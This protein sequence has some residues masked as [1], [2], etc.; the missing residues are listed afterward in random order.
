MFSEAPA[1]VTQVIAGG[2]GGSDRE[3]PRYE[4]VDTKPPEIVSYSYQP[5]VPLS[6]R[7]GTV[8]AKIIDDVEVSK[9][10]LLYFVNE[11]ELE[12]HQVEMQKHNS[13]YYMGTIPASDI[14][15]VGL[16]YWIFAEDYG[17]NNVQ[18]PLQK[19]YVEQAPYAPE[20]K[21]T[22]TN[23]PAHVLE[24][25]NSKPKPTQPVEKLEVI[26]MNNGNEI[27]AYPDK[28]IIKN[29]GNRTVGNVRVILSTDISKSFK[30]SEPAI[31]SIEPNSNV[32]ITLKL[33]G[34]P[35]R[36]MLGGLVGYK[37][38]LMVITEHLSPIF[39][40]VNIGAV[41]SYHLSSYI[42][43]LTSIAEQ[44]QNKIPLI[45]SILSKQPK[46]QQNYEVTT[47]D[48]DKVIASASDELVIKNLSDK[49]LKNVR[50]YL[51]NAGNVFLLEQK[52]IQYLEPNGQISIKLIPRIDAAKYS[53]KDIKGELYI[54]PSNDKPTKI[55]ID[56]IGVER[57]D[58]ADEFEVR[59]LSGNNGIFTAS[60]K[61]VIKNLGNRTLDSVRL[62]LPINL[63][64][65][66]TLS[67][68]SFKKIEPNEEVTVDIKFRE[69]LGEHKMG[70]QY[71][72]KGELAIVS[73]HHRQK[74]IP[75]N[76]VWN[77]FSSDHFVI[78]A[79]SNET[80]IAKAK[81]LLT[82]L[83]SNYQNV[84]SRFGEM[85]AKTKIYMTNTL[86]E[87][88]TIA[89]S[90]YSYY[91]F[92]DDV[93]F[94]CGCDEDVKSLAMKEF[95]HRIT[96]NKYP[97]YA[98]KAK[99]MLDGE[100]WLI[101]G[102]ANYIAANMTNEGIVKSQLESFKEKPM[103]FVW[104]GSGSP[105]EYGAT[106][107]FF[108]YL[109]EKYGENVI[110]K[111]LYYL[112]SGMISNHRCD[113]LEDCAVL[114]AVYDVSG[115]DMEKKRHAL[116]FEILVKEWEDYIMERYGIVITKVESR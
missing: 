58:S 71:N 69:D 44:R 74:V 77:E 67:S 98:N 28:I 97:N 60:D 105:E 37:G 31:K 62:M 65:V 82:F 6:G 52:N 36:D 85:K 93:I 75:I 112:G 15:T 56:I 14:R 13:E 90:G 38:K 116:D 47:S 3:R 113:T 91:V 7:E 4:I 22:K 17:H 83:E 68:D 96:F 50:I 9:V 64:R 100:N 19:L 30:L 1:P 24:A 101:D 29:T 11:K 108:E 43:T 81:E 59:T 18:S 76:I 63:A 41:Q 53:P 107:T 57:K 10:Y 86:E 103:S 72:Y 73:E 34:S 35:N 42:D 66:L 26:S 40:P 92:S 88:R 2:S 51:S 16:M 54:V 111:T 8:T 95:V 21:A 20:A 45:N 78:Y 79:R 33:N 32:T 5:R 104:Y 46:T 87:F 39:L 27:K 12:F 115:L 110:D 89:D 84:T 70:L 48:G 80:D 114:R 55:P 23:L 109:N 99:F 49:E 61:I 94:I 102:I 25:I 106:Y